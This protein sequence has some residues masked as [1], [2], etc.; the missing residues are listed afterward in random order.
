VRIGTRSSVP[1]RALSIGEMIGAVAQAR[2]CGLSCFWQSSQSGL[3]PVIA[4]AVAGLSVAGLDHGVTGVSIYQQ[5]PM[6]LARQALTV[7]AAIASRLT[8]TI[9]PGHR[10]EVQVGL[11]LTYDRPAR[12]VVEFLHVLMPLLR[13]ETTEF[14]G[15][16]VSARGA[17]T[18]RGASVPRVLVTAIAPEVIEAAGQLADG[19]MTEWAGVRS[20]E[21]ETVRV[22]AA[23]G[24]AAG[25]GQPVVS[26]FLPVAVTHKADAARAWSERAFAA[27]RTVPSYLARFAREGVAGPGGLVVV[28][29]ETEVERQLLRY[30]SAGVTDFVAAPFGSAEQIRR[31][32]RLLGQLN[33]SR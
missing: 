6:A 8:L 11:G 28:G 7:Q 31:T 10:D 2:D 22:S 17:S 14:R 33:R 12:H 24:S 25:R 1:G 4:A 18:V 20:I 3:D 19:T 9:G 23:A 5:H 21:A 16:F 32:V 15:E 26:V 13:G 29:D 27:S 30:E